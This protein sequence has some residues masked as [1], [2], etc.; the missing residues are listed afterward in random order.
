MTKDMDILILAQ[1]LSETCK[2]LAEPTFTFD[3]CIDCPLA[4]WSQLCQAGKIEMLANGEE[5]REFQKLAHSV[6][7]YLHVCVAANSMKKILNKE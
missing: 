7:D 5:W 4:L 1:L 6:S 2:I 3:C